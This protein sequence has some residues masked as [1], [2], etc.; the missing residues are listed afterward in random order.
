MWE[1]RRGDHRWADPNNVDLLDEVNVIFRGSM[2]IS[3]KDQGKKLER[4]ISLA[5]RIELGRRMKW[6]ETDI[7]FGSEDHPETELSTRVLA[8]LCR[9]IGTFWSKCDVILGRDPQIANRLYVL[10]PS[11][12]CYRF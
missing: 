4:E 3:S 2:S 6:S 9:L 11:V 12:S 7:L 1:P 5:Q 8:T 10:V